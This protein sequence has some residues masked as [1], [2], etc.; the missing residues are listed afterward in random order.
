[1]GIVNDPPALASITD[2]IGSGFTNCGCVLGSKI[3]CATTLTAKAQN[4]IVVETERIIKKV[5]MDKK[6]FV[7]F[8][9]RMKFSADKLYKGKDSK[10]FSRLRRIE[11]MLPRHFEVNSNPGFFTDKNFF[12][13]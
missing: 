12:R 10:L 4:M 3:F 1:M 2:G 11:E 9:R 6:F 8:Q 13:T 7:R 5:L